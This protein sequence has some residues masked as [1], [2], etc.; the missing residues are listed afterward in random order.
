MTEAPNTVS[1]VLAEEQ[2]DLQKAVRRFLEERAPL[3]RAAEMLEPRIA[4]DD[5]VWQ[6]LTSELGLAAL[7]IPE[8]CGGAGASVIELGLVLEETGKVLLVSPFFATTALATPALLASNAEAAAGLLEGIAAGETTATF[9]LPA[10]TGEA[11]SL[12]VADARISGTARFVINGADVDQILV[13]STDGGVYAVAR[14]AD[15]VSISECESTDPTRPL[16]HVTFAS[17]PA[18]ELGTGQ[19]GARIIAHATNTAR[20]ML[21]AE[22]AGAARA[23]LE[24]VVE[25]AKTRE[26]GGKVIG[27]HQGLKHMLADTRLEVEAAAAAARRA[28]AELSVAPVGAELRCY[29][30]AKS[31]AAEALHLAAATNIQAHGAIG[32]TWEHNAHLYFKR[33]TSGRRML[34][35]TSNIRDALAADLLPQAAG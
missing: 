12:N 3:A 31:F 6:T 27:S 22:S 13:T 19:D 18:T 15:G 11:S 33:A 20:V 21:A 23:A 7:A 32:F 25:Y 1:L 5:A 16:A 8:E 26:Q 28:A 30:S 17:S 9:A 14:D 35:I 2:R 4:R 24:M 34:G 29:L 10:I